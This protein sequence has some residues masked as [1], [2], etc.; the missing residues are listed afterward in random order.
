MGKFILNGKEYSGAPNGALADLTD[1]DIETPAEGQILLYNTNDSKWQ[2]SNA[3]LATVGANKVLFRFTYDA[4]TQKYGY[5]DG[6]DT[7]HPFSDGG[8][9]SGEL[10]EMNCYSNGCDF[11]FMPSFTETV[12]SEIVT[13]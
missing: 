4:T 13:T 1:T 11:S 10:Y 5:L 6:A 9:G 12:S 7:F 8:G 3:L 2:N